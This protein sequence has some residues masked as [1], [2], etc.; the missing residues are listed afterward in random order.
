LIVPISRSAEVEG[1]TDSERRF[2]RIKADLA[3]IKC[4]LGCNIVALFLLL[5]MVNR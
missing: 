2:A 4:M 5:F 3:I 1:L